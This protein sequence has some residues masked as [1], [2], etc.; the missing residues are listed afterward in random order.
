MGDVGVLKTA[1]D[2]DD[3]IDFADI[4]QELVAEAFALGRAA[5][6]TGDV[7]KLKGGGNDLN[8]FAN[9]GQHAQARVRDADTTDIGFDRAER[10]IGG[11]CRG[12]RSQGIEQG[13]FAD[14]GQADDAAVEAHLPCI[15]IR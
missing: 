3:G 9:L 5:H 6:Q 14:I 4:G 1:Q 12:G 7:D 15:P 2:V 11:L 13:R 10:I 8:G